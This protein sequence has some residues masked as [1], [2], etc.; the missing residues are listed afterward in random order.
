MNDLQSSTL[1]ADT[2]LP[3]L[4]DAAGRMTMVPAAE[5]DVVPEN[6]LRL[7]CHVHA[8]YG[9][10]TTETVDWLRRFIDG[11]RA[12]EI[13]AGAGDLCHRLCILGT[14][15]KCQEWLHVQAFYA[16]MHQP[17]I[18]YPADV[19]EMDALKAIETYRPE[20][21]IASWVTH[22]ID[23][24]LPPPPG[25]GSMYGVKEDKI[26]ASG[27]VYVMMGNLDTHAHKPILKLPH[28]EVTLPFLRSRG[29]ADRNRIFIW[30]AELL[31]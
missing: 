26:V 29:Q 20:V 30:N 18:K 13:G 22:W 25:G 1:P 15:N 16:A 14:D 3:D 27:V 19:K 11:R 12:I 24:E 28:R 2:P 31:Q 4:L 21:V 10:A 7:W 17:T 5:L 9:L 23:P 6:S 8:R